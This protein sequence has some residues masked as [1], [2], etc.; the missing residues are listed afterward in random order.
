VLTRNRRTLGWQTGPPVRRTKQGWAA[1]GT[2]NG[3]SWKRSSGSPS[4]GWPHPWNPQRVLRGRV[5][6]ASAPPPKVLVLVPLSLPT[7]YP[8]S[9]ADR[10]VE[11]EDDKTASQNHDRD[12]STSY[13]ELHHA[14]GM[15]N[16]RTERA[17]TANPLSHCVAGFS[18]STAELE[19]SHWVDGWRPGVAA[20]WS[21]GRA[22]GTGRGR[23]GG[24][25]P[26]ILSDTFLIFVFL[27]GNVERALWHPSASWKVP[28]RNIVASQPVN[29]NQ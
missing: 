9:G 5:P 12:R 27:T 28:Q 29:G 2:A 19:D 23:E 18:S 26:G 20:S 16:R 17:Q 6:S 10:G 21:A 7:T 15:R 11:F 1:C 3:G 24:R 22:S 8:G 4:R 14:L 25:R 13:D